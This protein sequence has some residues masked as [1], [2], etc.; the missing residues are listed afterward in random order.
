MLVKQSLMILHVLVLGRFLGLFELVC[1]GLCGVEVADI[2]VDYIFCTLAS[3][4][5]RSALVLLINLVQIDHLLV[6][7]GVHHG[8][9]CKGFQLII[10]RA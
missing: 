6:R 1:H 5:R 7:R 2:R 8:L 4:R 10:V 9:V 3:E